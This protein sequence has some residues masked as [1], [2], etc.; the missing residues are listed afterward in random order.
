MSDYVFGMACWVS[1]YGA[2][3]RAKTWGGEGCMRGDEG[4]I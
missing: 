1:C 3:V 2:I 4:F